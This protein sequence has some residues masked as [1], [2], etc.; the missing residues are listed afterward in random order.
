MNDIELR[1]EIIRTGVL[2]LE[3]G[4]VKGTGGNISAR[5]ERGF[6]ITPSGMDYRALCAGDIVE[7]DLSCRVICGARTPSVEKG[8]HAAI[9]AARPDVRAI[10]HVHSTFAAAFACARRP[11][12]V[13]ND[14][15]AVIFG[16]AVPVADYAPIGTAALAAN[17]VSALGC[18][19]GVLL[20]N[21]GALCVGG[22]VSEALFRCEML[23]EFAKVSLFAA[24]AGGAVPLGA[25]AARS[26]AEDLRTR[27]GQKV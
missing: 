2:L 1:E 14:N 12:E 18:G 22:P 4:L 11:L 19:A 7:L 9:L 20:A 21:H 8:M 26:E 16:G 25:D 3:K 15:Q 13:S 5:T 24:L 10:V 27:Y 23:E 17:A 6:L